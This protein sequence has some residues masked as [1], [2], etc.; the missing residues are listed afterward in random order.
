[1]TFLTIEIYRHKRDFKMLLW[2]LF[3]LV[4]P[5]IIIAAWAV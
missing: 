4:V 3:W 1:M 2:Y 5:L